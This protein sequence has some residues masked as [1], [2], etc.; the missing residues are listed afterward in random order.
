MGTLNVG[1]RIEYLI[2]RP[3]VVIESPYAGDVERNLTYA[4]RC[5]RDSFDRGED[6]YASHLLYTQPGILN[7][8]DPNER[9]LGMTAGF[10]WAENAKRRAFYVDFGVSNGMIS[11]ARAALTLG[12]P[13]EIRALDREVT[14]EDAGFVVILATTIENAKV[15][16]L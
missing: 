15:L 6:P 2:R 11:G 9:L 8:D 13:I 1:R 5:M 16:G 7:D 14:V 3:L 10:A 4:R 12:T